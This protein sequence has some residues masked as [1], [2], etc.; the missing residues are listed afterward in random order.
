MSYKLKPIWLSTD[1]QSKSM[2]LYV[3]NKLRGSLW[4]PL[5]RVELK[6]IMS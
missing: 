2:V 5:P 3:L 4:G 1:E 6:D